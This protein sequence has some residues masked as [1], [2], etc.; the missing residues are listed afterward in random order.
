MSRGGTRH[1]CG[2]YRPHENRGKRAPTAAV[3]NSSTRHNARRIFCEIITRFSFLKSVLACD[4]SRQ[5]VRSCDVTPRERKSSR[6]NRTSTRRHAR[7]YLRVEVFS[8]A[9]GIYTCRVRVSLLTLEEGL[10]M[11]ALKPMALP[12]GTFRD[13]W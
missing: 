7:T 1:D 4:C 12:S 13:G 3:T 8:S 2:A 9:A 6:E 11:R 10:R 5:A